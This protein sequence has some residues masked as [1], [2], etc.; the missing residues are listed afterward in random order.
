MSKIVSYSKK[1][2]T[3]QHIRMLAFVLF[4]LSFAIFVWWG[5]GM[6]TFQVHKEV[7]NFTSTSSVTT[8]LYASS[9]K[10][11]QLEIPSIN[12]STVFEEPV[13][14]NEDGSIAVPKE[15]ETVA[16]YENGP[17]PGAL[18]P[19]II[20][21]HVDSINGP[22][23]F[24]SLGQVSQGDKV[25]VTREDGSITVFS[26]YELE[27]VEQNTF[28]NLKVYGPTPYA[29]VRLITCSGTY[30]RNTNR[31]SHNLIV[32]ARLTEVI[33]PEAIFEVSDSPEQGTIESL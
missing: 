9:S 15:N 26:I 16:W 5:T 13:G 7:Q 18:G 20:L 27:R 25:R 19:S 31:Y 30:N 28:P 14:L 17:T 11:T 24:Y 1:H 22:A 29:E 23:I 8:T 2:I 4:F 10:P 32:Y 21:G 33:P 12:L 3:R 6:K